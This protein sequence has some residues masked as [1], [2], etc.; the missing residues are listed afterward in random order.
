M[1][2][3]SVPSPMIRPSPRMRYQH[4]PVASSFK[5][6]GRAVADGLAVRVRAGLGVAAGLGE[7]EAVGVREAV[8]VTEP[9]GVALADPEAP[10]AALG[11]PVEEGEAV[12]PDAVALGLLTAPAAAP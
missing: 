6:A 10:A 5:P 9:A 8:G 3:C 11:D 2:L 1:P 4:V 7:A 12:R